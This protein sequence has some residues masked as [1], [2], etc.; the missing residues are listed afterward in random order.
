MLRRTSRPWLQPHDMVLN[1]RH[2]WGFDTFRRTISCATYS[3][4][5]RR[6]G[7]E[8]SAGDDADRPVIYWP[9]VIPARSV[10]DRADAG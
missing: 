2:T 7:G 1:A 6:L 8:A 4:H 10:R 5:A 3:R 9:A